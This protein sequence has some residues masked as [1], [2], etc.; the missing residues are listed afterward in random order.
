MKRVLLII[1]LL[2]LFGGS[3]AFADDSWIKKQIEV[4]YNNISIIIDGKEFYSSQQPFIH[5]GRTY[6]PLRAVGEALGKQVVWDEINNRVLINDVGAPAVVAQPKY[7]EELVVLR[8]VGPFYQEKGNWVIANRP[9]A[10]GVAVDL[11]QGD[12]QAEVVVDLQQKYNTISGYIGVEDDTQNSSGKFLLS[13]YGDG[14][15]II[16]QTE[17]APGQYPSYLSENV[18][19]V[20]VLTIKAQWTE[21][22]IGDYADVKAVLA[23]FKLK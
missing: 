9:F 6:V 14:R 10:H 12:R 20:K 2:A 11:N 23:D 7:I 18:A 19:G 21:G 1:F 15:E 16:S 3:Q 13:I 4:A 17:F 8:N 22:G 5:Q